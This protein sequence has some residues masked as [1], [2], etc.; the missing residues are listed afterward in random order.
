MDYG[1]SKFLQTVTEDTQY[2]LLKDADTLYTKVTATQ[3]MTHITS[4]CDGL[5]VINI[6]NITMLVQG[7]C[8]N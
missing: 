7:L 5:H 3:F 2:K 1:T 4:T 8:T 6:T